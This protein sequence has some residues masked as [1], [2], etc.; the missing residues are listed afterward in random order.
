MVLCRLP[1]AIADSWIL[2]TIPIARLRDA[3]ILAGDWV[4]RSHR[5]PSHCAEPYW[6]RECVPG[7]LD[8]GFPTFVLKFM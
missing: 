7:R 6:S 8:L 5:R 3:S 4:R 1:L 2:D